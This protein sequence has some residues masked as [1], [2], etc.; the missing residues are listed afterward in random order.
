[1]DSEIATGPDRGTGR[2]NIS[3]DAIITAQGIGA[4]FAHRLNL[5]G[6]SLGRTRSKPA[7]TG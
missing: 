4:A 5:S 3:Q 7:E 2:F 6:H 1:M